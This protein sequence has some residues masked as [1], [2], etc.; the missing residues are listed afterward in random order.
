[1]ALEQ[2]TCAGG[3][4]SGDLEGGRFSQIVGRVA[5]EEMTFVKPMER[6]YPYTFRDH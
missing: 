2:N 1:M 5:I 6:T 4:W 3:L